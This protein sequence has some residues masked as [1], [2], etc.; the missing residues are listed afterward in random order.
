[1]LFVALLAC[2]GVVKAEVNA[3]LQHKEI[4]IGTAVTEVTDGWYIL[5]NVGRGNYVSEETTAMKMR[6]TSSVVNGNAA[7][8]KAGYLFKITEVSD[9]KYNIQS[10]NGLY[11]SLGWNSS[12]ISASPVEYEIIRLIGNSTDNF[13]L[14]DVANKYAADGQE[15]DNGFVGWSSTIPA[16]AGGN[17]SYRLLPVTLKEASFVELVYNFVYEGNVKYTHKEMLLQGTA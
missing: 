10:G 12:A 15:T 2:M 16:S 7:S 1:M 6:A 4:E 5:N 13:C 8:E 3:E 9:G 17:D 11:F 14:Y